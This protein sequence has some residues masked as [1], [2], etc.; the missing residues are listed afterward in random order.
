[1]IFKYSYVYVYKILRETIFKSDENATGFQVKYIKKRAI[2]SYEKTPPT[3]KVLINNQ[4]NW[5]SFLSI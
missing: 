4:K 1:M 3:A 5:S 2:L